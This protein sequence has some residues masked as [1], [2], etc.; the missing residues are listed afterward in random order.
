MRFLNELKTFLAP[1]IEPPA[2]PPAEPPDIGDP[3]PTADFADEDAA[4]VMVA[5]LRHCGCP[6]AEA[7]VHRAREIAANHPELKVYLVS[8][9][10][11]ETTRAWLA[12]IGG[13]GSA[14][15]VMDESLK[16]YRAWGLGFSN[17]AHFLGARSLRSVLRLRKQGIVNRNPG[18]YR[19]QTAGTFAVNAKGKIAWRH[20]PEHGGDLPDFAEALNS[21]VDNRESNA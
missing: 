18:G 11:P 6:F 4:G 21:F 12:E 5:F 20:L 19:R 15:L 10:S 3:T 9:A 17:A 13:S 14:V 8:H 2:E 1:R 7:T 16:L